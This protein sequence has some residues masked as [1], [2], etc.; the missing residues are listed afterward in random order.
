MVIWGF[1]SYWIPP[2][3]TSRAKV[4]LENFIVKE[5]VEEPDSIK[6]HIHL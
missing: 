5:M 4:K 6:G 2:D 3:K 1:P